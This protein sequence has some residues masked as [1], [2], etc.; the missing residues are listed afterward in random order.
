MCPY[1]QISLILAK[2]INQTLYVLND[3]LLKYIL[4]AYLRFPDEK[5]FHFSKMS[6][7][8][9]IIILINI[10]NTMLK[11]AVERRFGFL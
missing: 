11:D 8:D 6:N 4:K 3:N 7:Y 1:F 9:V 5:R 10:Q 2:S